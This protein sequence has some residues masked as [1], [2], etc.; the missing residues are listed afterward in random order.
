MSQLV[1]K[2]V[3]LQ[4]I[5]LITSSLY[6]QIYSIEQWPCVESDGLHCRLASFLQMLEGSWVPD[7]TTLMGE[8][9]E[10][11]THTIVNILIRQKKLK[12]GKAS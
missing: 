6:P 8:D 9:A 12:L 5:F 2:I 10:T 7:N 4:F 1:K 3:W 11:I